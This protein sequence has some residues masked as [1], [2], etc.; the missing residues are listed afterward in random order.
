MP[1][2]KIAKLHARTR[3]IRFHVP[4]LHEGCVTIV[5]NLIFTLRDHVHLVEV[6]RAIHNRLLSCVFAEFHI[7]D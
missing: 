3:R 5:R 1:W 6:H 2:T 7:R 4:L